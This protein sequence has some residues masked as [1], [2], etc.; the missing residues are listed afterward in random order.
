M[1]WKDLVCLSIAVVGIILFLYGANYYDGTVGWAGVYVIIAGVLAEVALQ[2]Y[3]FLRE[4][5]L[6]KRREGSEAVKL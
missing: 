2:I 1:T 3:E 5:V 6:I 4:K